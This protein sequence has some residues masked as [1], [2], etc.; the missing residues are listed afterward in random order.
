[1]FIAVLR[2]R[3]RKCLKAPRGATICIIFYPQRGDMFI[4]VIVRIQNVFWLHRAMSPPVFRPNGVPICIMDGCFQFLSPA[5]RHV[6]SSA[7]LQDTYK[8]LKAPEGRHVYHGHRPDPN[9]GC[10]EQ[11]PPVFRPQHMYNGR[12]FPVF[13]PSGATCL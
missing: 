10:I 12:V 6:Y 2:S 13:S 11:L 8:R 3:V 4:G 5:G 9:S 7:P 1:M